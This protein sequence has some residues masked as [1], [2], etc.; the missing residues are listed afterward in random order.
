MGRTGKIILIGV[1]IVVSVGFIFVPRLL[2]DNAPDQEGQEN[3]SPDSNN[4]LLVDFYTIEDVTLDNNL[5]VTGTL[6]ANESVTLRSEVSGIVEKIYFKEGQAVKKGQVLVQLTD[7]E[8][9]AEIQTLQHTRKLNEDM[10][11]RQKQ[12]LAKDAISQEEY[13]TA[14]T[15]L[16]TIKSQLYLKRV[17]LEKRKI[18][19]PFDGII[20]L[21]EISVGTYLTPSETI[22]TLYNT[23]PIKVEFSVPGKYATEVN[24]GD[25]INFTIDGL[26]QSFIGRIYAVEPQIDPQTRNLRIR[27]FSDNENTRLL[28]GQ[29]A[30]IQ[31]T[32]ETFDNTIM[33]PS[34]SVIP[35]MNGMK[36]F[37][38]ED[39]KA[40]S[41]QIQTGIRTEDKLQV[42]SGLK[43]GDTVITSGTLQL[44]P[45]MEVRLN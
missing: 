4:K 17:Q 39:G 38:Y 16:N 10:E 18:K 21:R 15:T 19:A 29:F 24:E 12:L 9:R 14:L 13:E 26:E 22:A 30:K 35:E 3:T 2:K 45:G 20:G 11:D 36:V 41:R 25:K 8:I 43:P 5:R 28:P 6:K 42:L 32:L 1:I 34:Q 7:D 37:V 44:R 23:N 31:L 40:M 27:A 33:I